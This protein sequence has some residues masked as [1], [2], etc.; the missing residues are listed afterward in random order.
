MTEGSS[1]SSPRQKSHKISETFLHD[2]F[3][4]GIQCSRLFSCPFGSVG[5]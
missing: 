5:G 2:R 1:L 4:I 3:H